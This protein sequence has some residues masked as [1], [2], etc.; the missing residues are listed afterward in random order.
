MQ[1]Y[2]RALYSCAATES[3]VR[4]NNL[5]KGKA[6]V[7]SY[8]DSTKAVSNKRASK[9]TALLLARSLYKRLVSSKILSSRLF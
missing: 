8:L 5:T 9:V 1:F 3:S 6:A 2:S 4:S 7:N